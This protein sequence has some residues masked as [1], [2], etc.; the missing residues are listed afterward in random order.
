M[1][2]P[3]SFIDEVRRGADPLR[4]I[5]EVVA[6]KK[7]GSRFV[8]LCPFHQEK[9]PS[10]TV[11][12]EGLWYCFGCGVGGDLFRFVMEQEAIGFGE[13]VRSIAERVGLPVPEPEPIAA[14]APRRPRI[15]RA[16]LLGALAAA[17]SFYREQLRSGAGSD[18]RK[19]LTG[20]GFDPELVKRFGLG[21]A[22]DSWDAL[23]GHLRKQG[24]SDAEAE[25][26]GLLKRRDGRSGHY[27]LLRNRIVFPILD[28]RSRTIAFGGRVV[29]A[30]E[31]KYLNSP[32]TPVFH[33]SRVLYGLCE[34]RD[35]IAQRGF[36]LLV[37]GYFDLLACAQYGFANAVAPLG[38]SFG[39]DH[40]RL[41]ARFTRKAVVSF[42]GDTAGQ[43][44]AERTVGVFLTQGF[45]VNVVRLPVEHDPDSLLQEQ[46]FESYAEKL[47]TSESAI[48][49]LVQRSGERADLDTPRGKAEAL[50][51]LLEFVVAV[52]DR[53]ERAEWLGRLA[54][55]LTIEPHL[56]EQAAAEML[57]KAR[58]RGSRSTAEVPPKGAQEGAQTGFGSDWRDELQDPPLNERGLLRAVLEHPEWREKLLEICEAEAIRDRRIRGLLDAAAEC[59]REAVD[60]EPAALLARCEVSGAD[61]VL[62]RV[63]VEEGEPLDW[64]G[65]RNCALG[66]RDDG[67]W[68]RLKGIR[69]A[70]EKAL[71]TGDRERAG[72]LDLEAVSLAKQIRST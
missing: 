23:Q 47:R 6:L 24:F 32:E 33:K 20:R 48:D 34:N 28:L 17:D 55:R 44:A 3:R 8:G 30:G 9:T 60:V 67:M 31:P 41:L 40:A 62:S 65:A 5:G 36:A 1:R 26:A 4:V 14:A 58:G 13:A 45:Q 56:V 69:K 54:E 11:N 22:P 59:E 70:I 72:S 46:G 16:R 71:E 49:F 43:S 39:E 21:F 35:G 38:T 42:D 64:N 25:A 37:E 51:M 53:V 15:D 27:D 18:A 68:R 2:Y 61:A 50:A 19:L 7:R 66:I 12:E 63:R 29:A 52:D 57:A 10:F